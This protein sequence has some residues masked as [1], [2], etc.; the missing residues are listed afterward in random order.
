MASR[1]NF[2]I[3]SPV[4]PTQALQVSLGNIGKYFEDFQDREMRRE[5]KEAQQKRWEAENARAEATHKMQLDEYNRKVAERDALS[6]VFKDPSK[7]EAIV[8]QG[9][10][11]TPDALRISNEVAGIGGDI[12]REMETLT[13]PVKARLAKDATSGIFTADN[14]FDATDTVESRMGST[15]DILDRMGTTKDR[16]VVSDDTAYR[17]GGLQKAADMFAQEMLN[18]GSADSTTRFKDAVVGNMSK[19][20]V[21]D[22][23]MQGLLS[24]G[25]GLDN[26]MTLAKMYSDDIVTPAERRKALIEEAEAKNNIAATASKIGDRTGNVINVGGRGVD[27]EPLEDTGQPKNLVGVLKSYNDQAKAAGTKWNT[28]WLSTDSYTKLNDF[29]NSVREHPDLKNQPE[30]VKA[31][32]ANAAIARTFNPHDWTGDADFDL[33][34]TKDEFNRLLAD[35]AKDPNTLRDVVDSWG[36]V[37]KAEKSR[38]GGSRN[39]AAEEFA[40]TQLQEANA[41]L[42]SKSGAPKSAEDVWTNLRRLTTEGPYNETRL[43]EFGKA[44]DAA[45]GIGGPAEI[46]QRLVASKAASDSAYDQHEKEVNELNAAAD[47][48]RLEDLTNR[49]FALGDV[50]GPQQ[51]G[52]ISELQ[53]RAIVENEKQNNLANKDV[54]GAV[55]TAKNLINSGDPSKVAAGKAMLASIEGT[56]LPDRTGKL[57]QLP[58][59]Y[60]GPVNTSDWASMKIASPTQ[61]EQELAK[62][63]SNGDS[64]K[65]RTYLDEMIKERLAATY[66]GTIGAVATAPVIGGLLARQAAPRLTAKSSSTFNPVLHIN[67]KPTPQQL[68]L[69]AK[70][71]EQS[72]KLPPA[73]IS[74]LTPSGP[75]PISALNS[76]AL[77]ASAVNRLAELTRAATNPTTG[78]VDL[79]RLRD[80]AL[81]AEYR[82]L[83]EMQ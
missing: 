44:M 15:R 17:V 33:G 48:Q 47:K 71:L 27:G 76:S 1:L 80:P 60:E 14:T 13:A 8:N 74:A 50:R 12:N 43:T 53:Q 57:V 56:R 35:A 55:T 59:N 70:S 41:L 30:Y 4:D 5:E 69:M 78:K 23:Y 65:Y 66:I 77:R 21:R 37:P 36:Q 40:L 16:R 10:Y 68:E 32:M 58:G 79:R 2:H 22:M 81:K 73:R 29:I 54:Q 82:R 51:V 52:P 61:E 34:G 75:A 25:V 39:K 45:K 7:M 72:S 18:S 49:T 11:S 38:L 9:V 26:A 63:W 6:S 28:N 20:Q 67:P 42:N 19:G 31:A 83:S 3:G 62:L 24:Q 46:A 64:A